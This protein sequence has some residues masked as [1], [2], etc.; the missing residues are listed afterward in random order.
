MGECGMSTARRTWQKAEQR[1]AE[2]FGARRQPGS[3]SGGRDDQTRSDSTHPF[4]FIESKLKARHTT[5]TL[6]DETAAKARLEGKLPVVCLCDKFRPGFLVVV[7]SDRLAELVNVLRNE[8][9]AP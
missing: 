7:H 4:L 6:Y 1:I 9:V 8:G 5:R 3:G 2:F